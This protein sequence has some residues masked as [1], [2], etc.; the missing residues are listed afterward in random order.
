MS[1]VGHGESWELVMGGKDGRGVFLPL[2]VGKGAW[3]KVSGLGCFDGRFSPST[4]RQKEGAT[5]T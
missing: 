3:T 4:D 5:Y 1:V 2:W